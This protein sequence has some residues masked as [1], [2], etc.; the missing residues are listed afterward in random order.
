MD[1]GGAL[2]WRLRQEG[3]EKK[4]KGNG[5]REVVVGSWVAC[6]W[7]EELLV[8]ERRLRKGRLQQWRE[9]VEGGQGMK[10]KR[11]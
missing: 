9:R 5:K 1:G 8:G 10:K 3:K 6:W 7:L 11:K 4:G 2:S